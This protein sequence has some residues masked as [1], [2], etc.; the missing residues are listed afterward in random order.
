LRLNLQSKTVDRPNTVKQVIKVGAEVDLDRAIATTL[1]TQSVAGN[2]HDRRTRLLP[3]I[4]LVYRGELNGLT[5]Y[6]DRDIKRRTVIV[7]FAKRM[8]YWH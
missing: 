6:L 5:L 4:R 1:E 7:K 8:I 2:R 3:R